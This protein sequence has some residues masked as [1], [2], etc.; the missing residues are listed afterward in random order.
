VQRTGNVDA[1]VRRILVKSGIDESRRPWR[2]EQTGLEGLDPQ[3]TQGPGVE[4]RTAL[5][6]ALATL[7]LGQ[8]RVVVLRHFLGMSI[9]ETAGDLQCSPGT[10][11]SQNSR[12]L[13]RLNDLLAP[14]FGAVGG[15]DR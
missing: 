12:A 8:R 10:V 11:K 15:N 13:A 14:Q 1:Y 4:D 9:E 5:M 2:R 3:V 6:D 7:P